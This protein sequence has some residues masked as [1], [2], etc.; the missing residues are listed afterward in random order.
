MSRVAD[1][2]THLLGFD[3][4]I[5]IDTYAIELGDHYLDLVRSLAVLTHFKFFTAAQAFPLVL[6]HGQ[7]PKIVSIWRIASLGCYYHRKI[8][9]K[10]WG[11]EMETPFIFISKRRSGHDLQE[12]GEEN[13]RCE[14]YDHGD[15]CSRDR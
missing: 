9:A 4:M 1:P 2:N 5:Q 12:S 7:P 10:S 15:E 6:P 14:Y 11:P 13:D 8:W 3:L